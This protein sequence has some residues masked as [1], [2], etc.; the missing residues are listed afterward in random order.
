MAK[1]LQ[2]DIGDIFI[3]YFVEKG[4]QL[5]CC[6]YVSGVY[7]IGL[8]EYDQKFVLVDIW[9]IQCLLGWIEDQVSGFEVF[10]D[11]IDDLEAYIDYIYYEE[12]LFDLYVESICWKLLEIFDWLDLQDI[13]EVVILLLMVI[14][15][16]INMVIVFMILILEC[17]N[18]IG[19]F[20][21]L[22]IFNWSICKVFL[23]YVVYIIIVGFFWG[24][25]FGIGLCVLQDQFEF[26]W[27]LEEN[28]YL[29]MVLIVLQVLLILLINLG[30]FIIILVFLL[31]LFYLV[32]NI[33]FVKVIR[34]K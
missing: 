25:F 17:I 27:F 8:E 11:D 5:Q 4:E 13:N 20:K 18:M 32:S 3:V 15:V 12:L 22:G 16:I 2:I 34:F 1:C 9:Q 29:S 19:I 31:L 33:S 30:M 10:I 28:Y 26:I 14:V 6:F 23:Y 24:N 7:W 21:V